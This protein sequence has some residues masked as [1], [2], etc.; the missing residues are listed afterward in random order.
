MFVLGDFVRKLG[1]IVSVFFFFLKEPVSVH[2]LRLKRCSVFNCC[3]LLSILTYEQ[4]F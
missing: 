4:I 2:V 3:I 1:L